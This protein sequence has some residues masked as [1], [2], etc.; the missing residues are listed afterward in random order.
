MTRIKICGITNMEDAL[1]AADLGADA[2][3]FI[4][5]PS[6]RRISPQKAREIISSLPPLIHKVG[7]FKND[8]VTLVKE[9]INHC[10]LDY[11]Q[12][13]G[14]EDKTYIREFGPRAIKVFEINRRHVMEEIKNF[15]LPFFMLDLPKGSGNKIHPDW[16]MVEKAKKW[17]KFMLAGGLNPENIETVLQNITPFGVDVCRGV[18]QAEGTKSPERLKEFIL[19][20][21]TW[22]ALRT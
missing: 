2:V 7:V 13:H 14:E 16:Q 6:P 1:L 5:T 18:E 3:G 12:F 9:I 4:F 21:R 20:V 22:D 11:A 17:G 10:F 19:K 8:E 15:S